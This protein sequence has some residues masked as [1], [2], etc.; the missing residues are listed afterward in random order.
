MVD[1]GKDT[2]Y[3]PMDPEAMAE[4]LVAMSRHWL[5]F[6]ESYDK[7]ARI[8][9]ITRW[10]AQYQAY[11]RSLATLVGAFGVAEVVN[12]THGVLYSWETYGA[13]VNAVTVLCILLRTEGAK[14]PAEDLRALAM[15]E[16]I[17]Y[18]SMPDD[19]SDNMSEL[20]LEK[21]RESARNVL[22]ARGL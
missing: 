4:V 12:I 8:N 6:K 14:I 13:L 3:W 22:T 7:S 11:S 2:V 5:E 10:L 15:V 18:Q 20:S 19:W 1:V 17:R 16:D 21:L 9:I